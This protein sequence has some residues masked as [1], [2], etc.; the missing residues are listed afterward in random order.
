MPNFERMRVRAEILIPS[1]QNHIV[2]HQFQTIIVIQQEL[3]SQIKTIGAVQDAGTII[4]C[5]ALCPG[6]EVEVES[7]GKVDDIHEFESSNEISTNVSRSI[8]QSENISICS[9]K[10]LL[11]PAPRNIKI[12]FENHLHQPKSS[13]VFTTKKDDGRTENAYLIAKARKTILLCFPGLCPFTEFVYHWNLR[14]R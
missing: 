13:D 5:V 6:L 7:F 12:F 9:Q 2:C 10:I 14:F 4:E 1:T 8:V 11:R 3:E